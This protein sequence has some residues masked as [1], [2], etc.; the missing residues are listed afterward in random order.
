MSS[1]S[2]AASIASQPPAAPPPP[3]REDPAKQKA[4]DLTATA[5]AAQSAKETRKG[6]QV[7]IT[8]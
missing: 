5:V 2:P 1:I 3:P 6:L 4:D 8:V 7:D